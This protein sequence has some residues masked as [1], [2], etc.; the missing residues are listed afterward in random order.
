VSAS[1]RTIVALAFEEVGL[2][3]FEFDATPEEQSSAMRR[4]DI[5]MA[6]WK[7]SS[8]DLG[9]NFPAS[10]GAGNLDDAS[11]LPDSALN[12]VAIYLALRI[13]PGIGKTLSVETKTAM[14]QGMIAL[15]TRYAVLPE[16]VLPSSTIRGAGAKP[17]SIWAPFASGD[18]TASSSGEEI[19]DID[20]VDIYEAERD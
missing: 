8:L 7:A 10:I 18:A 6:E 13:S 15:R 19:P 11:S 1:K 16:R 14:S 2:A 5:L 20:L 4:L 3:G 12:V 9:Y 17:G